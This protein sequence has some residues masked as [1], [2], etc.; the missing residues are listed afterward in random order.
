[1]RVLSRL[2]DVAL[3]FACPVDYWRRRSG[4]SRGQMRGRFS[5]FVNEQCSADILAHHR[6]NVGVRGRDVECHHVRIEKHRAAWFAGSR[7]QPVY[8]FVD[9][10][11]AITRDGQLG[12]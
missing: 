11:L 5:S 8:V 9:G 1:M 12:T 10:Q 6:E 4:R 7:P 2:C 3:S